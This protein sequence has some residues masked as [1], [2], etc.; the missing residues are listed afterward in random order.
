MQ[1]AAHDP[2]PCPPQAMSAPPPPSKELPEVREAQAAARSQRTRAAAGWLPE[3]A[4]RMRKDFFADKV[5][6]QLVCARQRPILFRSR[7]WLDLGLVLSSSSLA[8]CTP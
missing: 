7:A 3:G 6:A 8:L 2:P 1:R 5:R 4:L